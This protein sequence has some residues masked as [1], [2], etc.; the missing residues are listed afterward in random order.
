MQEGASRPA[1]LREA[2]TGMAAGNPTPSADSNLGQAPRFTR[3][4][5]GLA[6]PPL[7]GPA[8]MRVAVVVVADSRCPSALSPGPW[9]EKDSA[10]RTQPG[11]DHHAVAGDPICRGAP[12]PAFC[13]ADSSDSIHRRDRQAAKSRRRGSWFRNQTEPRCRAS[14]RMNPGTMSGHRSRDP[15]WLSAET[16]RRSD[17]QSPC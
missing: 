1:H 7:F 8:P 10:T 16:H 3:H 5:A 17:R 6:S 11:S 15:Q 2:Q 9:L 4:S 14:A 13:L 12:R